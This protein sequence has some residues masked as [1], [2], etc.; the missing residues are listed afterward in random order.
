MSTDDSNDLKITSK[1]LIDT[2]CLLSMNPVYGTQN[3]DYLDLQEWIIKVNKQLK[4]LDYRLSRLAEV[5]E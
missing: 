5:F 3:P 4:D 2:P 1:L